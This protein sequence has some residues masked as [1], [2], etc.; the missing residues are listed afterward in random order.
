MNVGFDL[1]VGEWIAILSL[2]SGLFFSVAKFYHV[3]TS[4]NESISKLN[5]TIVTLTQK[6]EDHE[7]RITTLETQA[8]SM[9]KQLDKKA[10]KH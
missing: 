3:F 4:L 8:V 7:R 1:S 9:F 5:E 2:A 6:Y 10:D